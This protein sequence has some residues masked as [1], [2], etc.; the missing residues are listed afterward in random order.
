MNVKRE[1]VA[2][3]VACAVCMACFVK[4]RGRSK[5]KIEVERK[6]LVDG[7]LRAR[8]RKQG[9]VHKGTKRMVDTYYDKLDRGLCYR[10]AWLR[11]R[12]V[13]GR[14]CWEFKVGPGLNHVGHTAASYREYSGHEVPGGLAEYFEG[15]KIKEVTDLTAS[16]LI[17]VLVRVAATRDTY[18]MPCGLT[19]DI[20]CTDEGHVVAEIEALVCTEEEVP[21]A[22][23]KIDALCSLLEISPSAPPA[24]GKMETALHNQ[25]PDLLEDLRKQRFGRTL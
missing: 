2:G 7:G 1:Y 24:P 16:G 4:N 5:G 20:D 8:I 10:D 13:D 17:T 21:S 15:V 19:V 18:R 9:G 22:R 12:S 25:C 11:S 6:V 14:S 23:K 3:V